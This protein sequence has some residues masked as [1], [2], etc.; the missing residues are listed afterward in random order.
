M[1]LPRATEPN[2]ET[3]STPAERSSASCARRIEMTCSRSIALIS[4][5]EPHLRQPVSQ[6][7]ACQPEQPRG[8]A[9]VALGPAQRLANQL[10][11]IRVETHALRQKMIVGLRAGAR[12]AFQLDIGRVEQRPEHITRLRSITFSNSRTFPGQ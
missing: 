2:S 5:F 7:V 6:R 4:S 11:L 3:L 1:W 8:L 12:R 10:L 9:L